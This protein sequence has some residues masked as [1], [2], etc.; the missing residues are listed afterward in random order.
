MHL[1]RRHLWVKRHGG[2]GKIV[3]QPLCR[4]Q[5]GKDFCIGSGDIERG[6]LLFNRAIAERT[7]NQTRKDKR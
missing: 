7:G 5:T 3:F 4:D 2:G 6:D 1:A